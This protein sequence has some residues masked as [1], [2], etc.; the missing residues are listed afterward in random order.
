MLLSAGG[1]CTLQ[2]GPYGK[3]LHHGSSCSTQKLQQKKEIACS[4]N[5]LLPFSLQDRQSSCEG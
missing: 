3:V 4:H 2:L 5:M 1:D